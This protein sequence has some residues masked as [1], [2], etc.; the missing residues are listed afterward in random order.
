VIGRKYIVHSRPMAFD[1]TPSPAVKWAEQAETTDPKALIEGHYWDRLHS[2]VSLLI[3]TAALKC[4]SIIY[5]SIQTLSE[6]I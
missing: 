4:G 2:L 5:H 6:R 1:L 3:A